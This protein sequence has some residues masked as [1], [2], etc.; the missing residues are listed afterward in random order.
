MHSTRFILSFVGIILTYLFTACSEEKSVKST[1][2]SFLAFIENKPS[3]LISGK[4]QITDFLEDLDYQQIPKVNTI[5]KNEIT[6]LNKGIDLQSPIFYS[7]DSLLQP[8]GKPSAIY[9]FATVKN[10]DSLADKLSSLGLLVIPNKQL[11]TAKGTN[12]CVGLDEHLAIF[13]FGEK[14]SESQIK[15]SFKLAKLQEK[16][17]ILQRIFQGKAAL[18]SHLH[19]ANMQ[20]MIDAQFLDRNVSKKEEL[21]G[22]YKNAYISSAIHF[23]EGKVQ[24]DINF[25]FPAALKNRMFFERTQNQQINNLVKISNVTAGLSLNLNPT[26]LETYLSD[27]YPSLLNQ[28]VSTNFTLQLALLSLGDKPISS[29][30]DGQMGITFSYIQNTL[31]PNIYIGLGSQKEL[32]QSFIQPTINNLQG[33][34]LVFSNNTLNTQIP[35]QVKTSQKNITTSFGTTGLFFFLEP[36]KIIVQQRDLDDQYK[37]LDAIQHITFELNNSGGKLVVQGKNKD[38]GLLNQIVMVYVESLIELISNNGMS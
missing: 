27:Y 28:A 34:N 11:T 4:I 23:Q 35:N 13:Q 14:A 32:I 7:V 37:F 26:K 18:Q 36:N 38:K 2:N 12:F 9:V 3:T 1:E 33:M 8:D 22:L 31:K 29:I 16:D 21:L 20:Q 17:N 10:K 19:L 15:E 6:Q 30:T 25:D 24:A 5:L